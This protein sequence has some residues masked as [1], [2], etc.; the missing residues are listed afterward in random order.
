MSNV[1]TDTAEAVKDAINAASLAGDLGRDVTA[2]R[3]WLPTVKLEEI[4]GVFAIVV[5]KANTTSIATRAADFEDI[6]IDVGLFERL[7]GNDD[8]AQG[9]E[10]FTLIQK[11]WGVL[12][13]S[14][15]GPNASWQARTTDPIFDVTTLE[16]QRLLR[17]A[18]TYTY[19]AY[20]DV[21]V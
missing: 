15:D 21:R 20:H 16:T 13:T 11:L 12:R 18:T 3:K 17:S 14:F 2:V 9:D 5:A 4:D 8:E 19:K 1:I 7:N 10:F 6:Q